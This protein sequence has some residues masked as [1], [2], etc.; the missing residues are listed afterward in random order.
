MLFRTLNSDFPEMLLLYA[1]E[2][3]TGAGFADR[4]AHL[5]KRRALSVSAEGFDGAVAGFSDAANGLRERWASSGIA[6]FVVSTTGD[7]EVPKNMARIWRS[8]LRKAL[9]PSF[10]EGLQYSIF[11]LGDRG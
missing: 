3:G 8:L 10:F 2:G 9:P 1:S 11:G 4:I 7:G 6:V 5:A